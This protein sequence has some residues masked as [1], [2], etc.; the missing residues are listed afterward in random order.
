MQATHLKRFQVMEDGRLS[1]S[2]GRVISFK[3]CLIILTSNVGS[4]LIARGANSIGFALHEG[5]SEAAR[6]NRM[7]ALVLEEFKSFFRPE[8]LNRLDKIVVR[9]M[10]KSV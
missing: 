8:F 1:D 9:L 5:D 7:R 6:D 4:H 2:R 3:E 10:L